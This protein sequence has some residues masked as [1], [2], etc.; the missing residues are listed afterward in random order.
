MK[1]SAT[2][3]PDTSAGAVTLTVSNLDR[4]VEFYTRKLG[5]QILFQD[6]SSARLGTTG[7]KLLTLIGNPAARRAS[8]AT[9]LF[10]FA[11]VLPSRVELAKMLRHYIQ[12]GGRLQGA[13]DHLVSEALYL[14]D[15]EGNG[16]ELYRDR[17]RQEWIRDASGI[18]MSTDPLDVERLIAEA[19]GQTQSWSGLPDGA[20]MGHVHL[21]VADIPAAE[22]FYHDVLGFDITARYGDSA[23]FFS[24]GGY[25]HHFAAN[26]WGSAGAPPPPA[27]A[28]GLQEFVVALPDEAELKR[29]AGRIQAAGIPMEET[30]DGVLVRDPSGNLLRLSFLKK[31]S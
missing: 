29:V 27:D 2:I 10:H 26:T 31:D 24:A 4:A 14:A 28:A 3:H 6:E 12:A 9:G 18:R 13:A 11:I 30:A 19:D 15:S 5:F 21:R 20:R 17:P 23:S 1:I 25:H 22:R 16:I 8:H 7:R